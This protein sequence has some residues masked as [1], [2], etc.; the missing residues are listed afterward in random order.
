MLQPLTMSKPMAAMDFMLSE[1]LQTTRLRGRRGAGG[2]VIRVVPSRL[3]APL[4]EC[5]ECGP[6]QSVDRR[7]V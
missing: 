4:Y 6:A 7:G 3:A 5:A 1:R 2:Q